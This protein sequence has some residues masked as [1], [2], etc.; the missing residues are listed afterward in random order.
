MDDCSPPPS[1][2]CFLCCVILVLS[3]QSIPRH[4]LCRQAQL[5]S[6]VPKP[7]TS[8]L[9]T[10][11]IELGVVHAQESKEF[12]QLSQISCLPY[13]VLGERLDGRG[14]CLLVAYSFSLSLLSTYLLSARLLVYIVFCSKSGP[15][16]GLTH[17]HLLNMLL[18]F[19]SDGI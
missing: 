1:P 18:F 13:C 12:V 4:K 17:K 11:K 5:V 19:W 10:F 2:V 9:G 6:P 16:V 7:P 8:S 3:I 14:G 15:T